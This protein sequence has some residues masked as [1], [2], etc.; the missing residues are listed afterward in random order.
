MQVPDSADF[1]RDAYISAELS[2]LRPLYRNLLNAP[3]IDYSQP[4]TQFAYIQRYV[5]AHADLVRQLISQSSVLDTVFDRG[6]VT[7]T[8]VGGG[9]GSDFLGILK[10]MTQA[11]KTATLK[12]ILYDREEAWGERWSDVDDKLDPCF[13]ISTV[14][15]KFDATDVS[16]WQSHTKYLN[17]DVFT[18]VYFLSE[19]YGLQCQAQDF[20][21]YLFRYAKPGSVFLYL[22]N[23]ASQFYG[24]F[25]SMAAAS[26][27]EVL[28][29]AETV[30]NI[31]TDERKTDL[32]V[33]FNKFGYPKLKA[34][35]AYR[36][37]RKR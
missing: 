19:T 7:V 31:G 16:S 15:Q 22:D 9:P 33:Y 8:C 26:G 6:K 1:P 25:D 36:I 30:M 5:T 37:C 4:V 2:R 14:F 28:E 27:L 3:Y 29:T 24:W 35:V 10:Y 17:S 21:M 23:N 13:R 34:D 18:L 20:F 32:G 11:E 12:C